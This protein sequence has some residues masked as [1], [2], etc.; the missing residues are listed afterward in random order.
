MVNENDEEKLMPEAREN[1]R[2]NLFAHQRGGEAGIEAP[3]TSLPN[4]GQPPGQPDW[5]RASVAGIG[6]PVIVTDRDGRVLFLNP[7]AEK[8]TGWKSAEALGRSIETVLERRASGP[9]AG[10][11]TS[12]PGSSDAGEEANTERARLS[13]LRGEVAAQLAS[14]D[15][16]DRCLQRCCELLVRHLGV[17]FV[18]VW[19][20]L[21]GEPILALRASAGLYTHLD[22]GH[23]RVPIGQ[24]K[25][26]RIARDRKPLLTNSVLEDPNISDPEW[27]RRERMIAFAG[28]PLLAE[29]RMVGVLAMFGRRALSP[30]I[31]EDLSPIADQLAQ[32]IERKR[33]ETELR[34]ATE[35]AESSARAVME[36]AERFRLLSEIAAIQVW[37]ARGDGQLDFVNQECAKYF[38]TD[39][40]ER[41]VLGDAWAQYV[42]P[43]DLPGALRV[44]QQC[45][46]SLSSYEVE[47]RL[48]GRDGSYR[49]FLVRAQPVRDET[50]GTAR[51]FGTNTDIHALKVAKSEAERASRAKDEFLAALSHELRTPLTP[52]L[53]TAAALRDDQSLPPAVREQLGMMERNIALEARLIDD[54]LDLTRVA[55]GK[56]D[57]RG[58]HCDAHS[59]IGLA[60]EIMRDDAM[61]KEISIQRDMAARY[62]GL[63][64]D[65]ARFQQVVWNLLRNA[66]KF[67]PRGGSITVSTRDEPGEAGASRLHIEVADSGIGINA[68][69]LEEIFLP[70]EQGG[71]TGNHQFGGVGLG[72]AIAR[73]IVNLHGGHIHAESDGENRGATFVVEFPGATEPPVGAIEP[74]P[75]PFSNLP[76][77]DPNSAR[78]VKRRL[79]LVEDHEPTLQVLSR[80]LE[81]DGHQVIAACTL[82][83]ALAAAGANQI[84]IVIS[85]LGLPDGTGT[86]L[87]EQLRDRYGLNGIALSGYG[88]DEDIAR[89][90]ECG[91]VTHLVKPVDF[92]QL[93]Q[94]IREFA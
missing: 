21:P 67:T 24:Y 71:L 48:R 26:G 19:T 11:E 18:R 72:L 94:A 77:P 43:E 12:V 64:A 30:A 58:Q 3:E 4:A 80:L 50:G 7:G 37:T 5:S 57:F 53:M 52:V 93:Q 74:V 85:D 16:L 9:L 39:N 40:L 42:H 31:L 63:M 51:W 34:L 32:C 49:W 92:H 8:L 87:M 65:P 61:Q 36:A 25:I 78:G 6:E 54:L 56:L 88:M 22:G 33:A 66:V 35:R 46:S 45:L 62:S 59:L 75:S 60:I 55:Q 38:G 81:R 68:T 69:Q 83:D 86:E 47:F 10:A 44:W 73:A 13:A 89:S 2:T 15:D 76:S 28:Y 70:F 17:A 82:S 79:L 41:D 23:A 27:A 90:R 14:A 84:D 91:F 20:V 29:E 1:A